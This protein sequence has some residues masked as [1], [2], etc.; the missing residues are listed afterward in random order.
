M[1]SEMTLDEARG[2]GTPA[3]DVKKL[4]SKVRTDHHIW[5]IYIFIVL[6]S[7]VELFSASIQEVNHEDIY[8]P[9]KRHVMFLGIGLVI[10]LGLQ[11]VH[12]RRIYSAIPFFVI[13]SLAA[14]VYVQFFGT[15]INGAERAIDLGFATVLPAEFLKLAAAL[16]VAWILGRSKKQNGGRVSARG[17]MASAGFIVACCAIL[18]LQGLS[19]AILVAAIGLSMMFVG[20]VEMKHFAVGAALMIVVG[21]CFMGYMTRDKPD[22]PLT[23]EQMRVYELNKQDPDSVRAGLARGKTWR[24][25]LDRFFAGDKH[26]AKITDENKQEQMSFIAQAHGG[27]FGVGPGNSRENARLPL[28]FSDYIFAIIVEE[29]GLFVALLLLLSY[30]WLLGRAAH[31]TMNFRQTLPGIMVIGCAFVIVFQALYHI[32]IVTGAAPVSGQPLPL[33]SKGGTCVLATSIA[34]G[35]ML[36]VSRHAAR[37]NDSVAVKQE[38]SVL[39]EHLQSEN[40]L[41][42]GKGDKD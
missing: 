15:K 1:E 29:L 17:F 6:I 23:T 2:A 26:T 24:A 21:A 11:F 4:T 19:N 16:G 30:L 27:F 5:G 10:M 3:D 28:A 9:I 12:Y 39:P 7:I 18:I 22:E 37:Y 20:G 33:I 42:A 41:T 35:V 31:L 32:A 13:G 36:S 14:M 25:R 34:L 38:L 8:G 40:P